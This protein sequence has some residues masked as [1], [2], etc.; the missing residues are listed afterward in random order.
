MEETE[1]EVVSMNS[2]HTNKHAVATCAQA[3]L[4]YDHLQLSTHA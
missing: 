2:I 1:N 3:L 4:S